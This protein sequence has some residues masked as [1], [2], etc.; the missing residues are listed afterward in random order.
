MYVNSK[1]LFLLNAISS[2]EEPVKLLLGA[3]LLLSILIPFTFCTTSNSLAL[4]GIPYFFKDGLTARHIVFFF[5]FLS[6]TT[7]LVF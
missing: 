1:S 2:Y 3:L 7:K 4:P 6:A 5:F